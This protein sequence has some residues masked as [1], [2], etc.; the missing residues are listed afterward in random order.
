MPPILMLNSLIL[1]LQ[2]LSIPIR[3]SGLSL[4]SSPKILGGQSSLWGYSISGDFPIVLLQ[5]KDMAMLDLVRQVIQAHAYWRLKG[6]ICDLVIW[7]EDQ[8]GYRQALQDQVLGLISSGLE[9]HMLDGN[10]G[11]FVRAAEQI[12]PEDRILFQSVARLVISDDRG[13]LAEQT[14]QSSYA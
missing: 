10:G 9:A 7:N 13:S 1:W 11:I 8:G 14:Q 4:V 3:H 2:R 5:I 12:S 6:L